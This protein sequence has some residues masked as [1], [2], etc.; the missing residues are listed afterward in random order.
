MG[1]IDDDLI[2]NGSFSATTMQ[3]PAGTVQNDDIAAAAGISASKC[4]HQYMPTYSQTTGTDVVTAT[5]FIHLAMGAGTIEDFEI[6]P[7]TAP[8]GGDKQ[9]TVD[10]QKASNGST[11]YASVLSAVITVSSSSTDGT[12]QSGTI[13]TSSY[14]DQDRL[15]IVITASGSTGSQG[16]GF[17]CTAK[18]REAA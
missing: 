2:I 18:I 9:F 4:E 6:T 12:I 8:T 11:T 7:E 13:T 5:E 3:I 1:R 10:L 17:T 15:R 16:Q 14:A